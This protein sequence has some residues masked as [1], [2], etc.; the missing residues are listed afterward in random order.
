MEKLSAALD[1]MLK[2][3]S[4][5]S[6]FIATS[7]A[8]KPAG[9]LDYSSTLYSSWVLLTYAAYEGSIADL[10]ESALGVLQ[11]FSDTPD[12][13]PD[14]VRTAYSKRVVETIVTTS[15]RTSS[16]TKVSAEE[17]V[18]S[19]FSSGWAQHSRLLQLDGNAW[20]DSV[21]ELLGRLGVEDSKLSWLKEP[22]DDSSESWESIVKRL[23]AERNT[24]AHGQASDNLQDA[25]KMS[26]WLS[27]IRT[28]SE[29]IHA[30]AC[31]ALITHFTQLIP[32]QLGDLDEEYTPTLG[33]S[34]N[35]FST[36]RRAVKVGD[37]LLDVRP[38]NTAHVVRV[39]SLQREGVSVVAAEAGDTRVAVSVSKRIDDRGLWAVR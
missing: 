25:A 38:D 23:V 15:R 2:R 1:G 26:T 34:T 24:L 35:A 13:L 22:A 20:P 11:Q 4:D 3:F 14:L 9:D 6:H 12:D 5:V 16:H 10:G 18:R 17:V 31:A 8:A 39:V 21:C 7:D 36:L 32:P 30:V 27:E 37:F 19:A 28:F 33:N 29:R